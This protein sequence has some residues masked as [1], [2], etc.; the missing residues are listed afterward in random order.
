MRILV[1]PTENYIKKYRAVLNADASAGSN[2]TLTLINNSEAAQ[3]D[4]LVIGIEGSETAELVQIN[5]AV[6]GA[7]NVQVATLKLSHKKGEPVT[8]YLYDKRKFYGSTTKDGS[9]TELSGSPVTI[10]P[11]DNQGAT[12]EYDG[13]EGYTYFKA[14][15][16]NTQT[17][18]ETDSDD[19]AAV[20]AEE[21]SRYCSLYAIRVQARLTDNPFIT[22]GR[23][24]LKR[25]QA[26][27]EINSAIF[28][29]YVLPL[30]EIPGIIK[31]ICELLAAGYLDYEEFGKDGDG[32]KWLGE[33]RG[34]LNSIKN[35]TQR[36]LTSD[37]TEL[38]TNTSVNV[39]E[40]FPNDCQDRAFTRGM[41]F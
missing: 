21:T 34:L 13:V 29:R 5:A 37:M 24:E 15:Y 20:L 40:G 4:Y 14:T 9:Y 30:S 6:S 3:Y 41:K 26:E 28:S 7:T 39:L 31:H 33:A 25:Q 32:V 19:S 27:S 36:L 22:D 38:P 12:L 16:Y 23:V 17:S 8:C 18:T 2:V 35:G 10:K 11:D 1:A